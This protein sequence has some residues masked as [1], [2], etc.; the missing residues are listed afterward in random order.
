VSKGME[1]W[2]KGTKVWDERMEVWD[3]RTGVQTPELLMTGI[4]L[5]GW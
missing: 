5:E 2:D 3:K 4:D 1:V